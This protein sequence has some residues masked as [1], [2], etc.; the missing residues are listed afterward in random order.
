MTVVYLDFSKAISA[1]YHSILTNKLMKKGLVKW[2]EGWTE[3]QLPYWPSKC[4]DHWHKIQV[5]A[6]S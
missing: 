6:S 5:E 3:K 2:A 1:A 4:C